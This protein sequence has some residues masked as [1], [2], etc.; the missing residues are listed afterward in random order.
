[1]DEWSFT[2]PDSPSQRSTKRRR[3][4][5]TEEPQN[6]LWVD[7]YEPKSVTDVCVRAEKVK[8]L[9]NAIEFSSIGAGQ[10][11]TKVLLLSGQC[12]IGKSTLVRLLCK[13]MDYDIL[14]WTNPSNDYDP[15]ST[16]THTMA[17]R[18]A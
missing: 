17:L 10:G 9:Q 6:Y 5:S 14:E 8:E 3:S 18:H 7:Q 15:T 2:L 13:S 16:H 1:M 11:H 4:T 12:G